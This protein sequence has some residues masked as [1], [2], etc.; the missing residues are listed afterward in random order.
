M[1]NYLFDVTLLASIRVDAP[2]EATARAMITAELDCASVNAG[3]W[4]D[5]SPILFEVSVSGALD[6]VEVDGEDP[7][8]AKLAMHREKW[9][10]M[11]AVAKSMTLEQHE[12]LVA[13]A[14]KAVDAAIALLTPEQRAEF[15]IAQ[16]EGRTDD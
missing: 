2:D 7:D 10:A 9:A 11:V 14:Q 4:P 3:C 8:F 1:T 13:D 16:Q 6:L 15:C 5:G 12:Q